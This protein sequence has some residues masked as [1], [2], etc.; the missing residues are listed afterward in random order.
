[1][2]TV[3]T[4]SLV[5]L[6]AFA[7][8]CKQDLAKRLSADLTAS[9]TT[10]FERAQNDIINYCIKNNFDAKRT[11]SGVYY[12]LENEGTG[13]APTD[14][15]WVVMH[16]S[17]EFLGGTKHSS[18]R[19]GGEPVT[20]ALTNDLK[21]LQEA[22]NT[23]K[24]GGKGKFM[25]PA[26]MAFGPNVP[27]NM[28][29]SAL[30]FDIEFLDIFDDKAQAKT[31]DELIQKYMTDNKLVAQKTPNGIYYILEKEGTGAQPSSDSQV[32]VHYKGTMLG[33]TTEF[34]SSY[35]RGQTAKF[36]LA[37]VIP[38]WR[39]AI[40]LLKVGGKGKFFIPSGLAYGP[41]GNQGIKPNSVL[42]FDVELIDVF[43]PEAQA[44]K[45]DE[46]IQ[47]YLKSKGLAAEKTPNGIYFIIEKQGSGDAPT[48]G[49]T[50]EV[51]YRGTLLD[52]KEFDSSYKRGEKAKFPLSQVI[53]GWQQGIPLLKPGGKG[54][55]FIPSGLAYGQQGNPSIPPNSPLIFEVEL[56]SV[57]N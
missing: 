2:K 36:G 46:A 9:P 45:D 38:G 51:D 32:E 22:F 55:L 26:T 33:D 4:F 53:P 23:M 52:G 29:D 15:A 39:Q 35:K 48:I 14:S 31:D 49:S 34:D 1:M 19:E 16:Y 40:P 57:E 8:G 13:A 43:D 42:V 30:I 3:I 44:K 27:H 18:S 21:G 11:E 37:Q 7:V 25:M 10:P 20:L 6:L 28:Q 17:A 54:K 41:R 5:G 24:V 56:Y 47:K 50:V 12:T